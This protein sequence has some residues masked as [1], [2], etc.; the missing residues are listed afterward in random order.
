MAAPLEPSLVNDII[1]VW[2]D[3]EYGLARLAET[4]P[5]TILDIGAGIGLFSI[6]ARK[7]FPDA[8]IHAY[9]PNARVLSYT[10]QNTADLDV[11]LVPSAVGRTAGRASIRDSRDSRRAYTARSS[12]GNVEIVPLPEIVRRLGGR[13]DLMKLDIEGAEWELFEE[14]SAFDAVG[15]IRME[16][17]LGRDRTLRD[18][19]SAA[20]RLHFRID[21]LA[22]NDGFG[23]PG[24]CGDDSRLGGRPTTRSRPG[25]RRGRQPGLSWVGASTYASGRP[26]DFASAVSIRVAP[27]ASAASPG[28]GTT[29][30]A[31]MLGSNPR[32][33]LIFE[34]LQPYSGREP[35]DHGFNWLNYCRH[36]DDWSVQRGFLDL[37]L[38]GRMLNRRTLRP[39]WLVF[40]PYRY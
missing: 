1:N 12:D 28:G 14:P 23:V 37:T 34:P 22:P 13:V 33:L 39:W 32:H 16:Y 10:R 19:A 2:L 11:R 30:L 27:S 4:P 29:W 15:V 3:D 38:G 9:E 17:H 8:I 5:M 21:K 20:E 6:W 7:L 36:G 35:F 24:G 26:A 18:I 31:E 40:S 25:A